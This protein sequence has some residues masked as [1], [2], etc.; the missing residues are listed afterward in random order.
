M[1]TTTLIQALHSE[2]EPP[3]A[4]YTS[5]ELQVATVQGLS[6]TGSLRLGAAFLQ[7]YFPGT[8]VYISSPTWGM[9]Q[10]PVAY[11]S[12]LCSFQRASWSRF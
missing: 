1:V 4:Y 9:D 2:V 7:R 10:T 11:N 12:P 6:G 3:N 5:I 8:T